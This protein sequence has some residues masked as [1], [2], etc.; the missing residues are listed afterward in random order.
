MEKFSKTKKGGRP[1]LLG[2]QLEAV[3][4]GAVGQFTSERTVQ[5]K[6]YELR[7]FSALGFNEDASET[8][9]YS[10]LCSSGAQAGTSG[11]RYYRSTILAELGRFEDNEM[12]RL[13]AGLICTLK[14]KTQEA[15]RMLRKWRLAASDE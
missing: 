4:R 6:Y 8:S 2:P 3:Y 15:V 7:A 5:N 1:K 14:P 9:P 11:R 10:W 12:M 13:Y